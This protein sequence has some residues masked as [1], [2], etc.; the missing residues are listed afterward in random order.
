[1]VQTQ[2]E[3]IL[4]HA[5]AR[6]TLQ[7]YRGFSNPSVKY[8]RGISFILQHH[9]DRNIIILCLNSA[10]RESTELNSLGT[11]CALCNHRMGTAEVTAEHA[12]PLRP[13]CT[14]QSF[15]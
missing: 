4:S 13:N 6:Q 15:F 11:S 2:C 5:N 14:S 10:V 1:M 7:P 8:T 12:F 3:P 9:R